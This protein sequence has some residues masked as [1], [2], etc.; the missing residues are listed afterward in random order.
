MAGTAISFDGHDLQT[1]NIFTSA[2]KHSGGLNKEVSIY[3]LANSNRSSITN[4]NYPSRTIRLEGKL[5]GDTIAAAED[6]IDTFNGYF[7]NT[8][9]N[10]DIGYGS[11]TRRYIA[12]LNAIEIDQPGGLKFANYAIELT[13]SQPFGVDT[14]STTI[15]NQVGYTSASL[16]TTPTI[17]GSAPV[18]YPLIT[19]TFTALTGLSD[20]IQI[21]NN[22]NNQSMLLYNYGFVAGDVVIID[23]FERTVKVNGNVADYYGTYL[24]LEPG[25]NSITYSD[26][27]TTR[28]V[29][30]LITYK[31]RWL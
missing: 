24:E 19:I 17:L 29:T 21:S 6:L 15:L 30:V 9:A 3:S 20:Y 8:D 1:A 2:I 16:T 23:T 27:F 11:G 26:G 18:Q 5:V 25:A 4:I 12:T 14:A 7:T 13:C 10:L 31:K 28:T 22:N